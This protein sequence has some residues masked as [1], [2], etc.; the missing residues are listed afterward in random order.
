LD[1]RFFNTFNHAAPLLD[2]LLPEL[3]K[4]G[5]EA[6]AYIS[7]SK[8]RKGKKGDDHLKYFHKASLTR[9]SRSRK[10]LN[11]ILYSISASFKIFFSPASF[12]V[13]F[14]HPPL[15]VLLGSW[16]SRRRGVPYGVHV[17]DQYPG[18]LGS[19]GYLDKE[20]WLYKWLDRKMDKVLHKAEFVTILG[21]CM[22]QLMLDKGVPTDKIN[23]VINVP[24]IKD[25]PLT[26]DYLG[27]IDLKEKFTVI[28]AGNMGIAHEF[29]TI[30][31][32]TKK[33]E[34]SSP[35]VHFIMLGKGNRKKEVEEYVEE[36]SPKNMTLVGYLENEE[37]VAI[38]KQTDLHLITL[39]SDFNGLMVPSKMYSSL[40]LGK[41][42]LFEGPETCEVSVVLKEHRAGTRVDHLDSKAFE[43]AILSYLNEA[44][45]LEEHGEN[46]RKYFES[47][48]S[49]QEFVENYSNYLQLHS[50]RLKA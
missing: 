40:A 43:G 44:K 4:R 21:N 49:I 20:G 37:F 17:M 33:M 22:R 24:T 36:N 30:L 42:I 27:S 48:C 3:N 11:L 41:P 10:R 26:V 31:S 34:Q 28:Y 15:Y 9:V 5:V 13:F 46:A 12:H 16:L 7:H 18:F 6:S 47:Y 45:K 32:V 35:A 38:M 14:T 25:E 8:Y 1:I 29:S 2:H 50:T 23:Q 39:R 19:A